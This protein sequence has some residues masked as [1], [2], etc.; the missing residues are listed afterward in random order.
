MTAFFEAWNRH[1]P[2]AVATAIHYPHVR[3]ADG[4]V[5]V[6][7]APEAFLAG[8][9]PGRQRTWCQT[10][11]RQDGRGADDVERREPGRGSQPA[12]S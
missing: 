1:D 10:R 2:Q 3:V 9:E 7:K 8:S 6:W 4:G 5:D 11:R 12:W